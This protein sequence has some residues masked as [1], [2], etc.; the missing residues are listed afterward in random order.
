MFLRVERFVPLNSTLRKASDP[1]RDGIS[2]AT[3]L[4]M[5]T[6]AACTV[7]AARD[8][9]D[10]FSQGVAALRRGLHLKAW[11]LLRAA[12]KA[13]PPVAWESAQMQESLCVCAVKLR[14]SSVAISACRNATTL[15]GPEHTASLSVLMARGE[16]QMLAGAP[17]EAWREFRRAKTVASRGE[18]LKQEKEAEEA[19]RRAEQSLFASYTRQRGAVVAT[20]EQSLSTSSYGSLANALAACAAMGARCGAVGTKLLAP[21]KGTRRQAIQATLYNSSTVKD[22]SGAK[23][24]LRH[25]AYVRDLPA[26]A[27]RISSGALIA[28]LFA[29]TLPPDVASGSSMTPQRA[30]HLC[31]AMRHGRQPCSGFVVET[32]GQPMDID[33]AYRVEFKT[34]NG[35]V[36]IDHPTGVRPN[37]RFTSFLHQEA[38]QEAKPTP[39]PKPQPKPPPKPQ[40]KPNNFNFGG[41]SGFPGGRGGPN[42]FPGGRGGPNP[43]GGGGGGGGGSRGAG[44]RGGGG[45]RG[46]QQQQQKKKPARDYY[47]ILK[48]PKDANDRKVKKA[49]HAMAKK[50][51]PD[52]NRQTGQEERLA[53]AERNFKLVARA[54]EVLSDPDVRAAYDRGEDVDDSKWQQSNYARKER[55]KEH[56][57]MRFGGGANGN[58]RRRP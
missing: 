56:E 25:V 58:F 6:L 2:A 8:A 20:V 47:A 22:D 30:M 23:P 14:K 1:A 12:Y 49:Y 37:G 51:H 48:V 21:N 9:D 18:A 4:T 34:V 29:R 24:S 53:K 57:R 35:N 15:R 44:G 32:E 55:E 43:F 19:V 50:W 42:G 13:D 33:T 3:T 52:K 40:P 11:E 54:Y 5:L 41:G 26:C 38:I 27:Y 10:P 36:G 17:R 45:P 16:A 28:G 46:Q 39:T 7:C 31:D